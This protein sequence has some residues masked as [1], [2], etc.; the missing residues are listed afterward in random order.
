M[1]AT[2][3]IPQV[4]NSSAAETRRTWMTAILALAASLA[5]MLSATPG[6]VSPLAY[7]V[8]SSIALV[9]ALIVFVAGEHAWEQMVSGARA[10]GVV[11]R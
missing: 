5:M 8:V 9:T 4:R 10:A 2:V 1:V 3:E 11:G 6:S 7:W